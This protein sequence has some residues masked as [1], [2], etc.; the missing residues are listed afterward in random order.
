MAKK[1]TT[2]LGLP[3]GAKLVSTSDRLSVFS[4]ILQAFS[5]GSEKKLRRILHD[6]GGSG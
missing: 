1:E 2:G 3:L 6:P 5:S 4:I